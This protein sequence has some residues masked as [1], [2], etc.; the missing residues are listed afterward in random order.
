MSSS[1]RILRVQRAVGVT[2][3]AQAAFSCHLFAGSDAVM[4][5]VRHLVV[6]DRRHVYQVV[7]SSFL[8]VALQAMDESGTGVIH[9]FLVRSSSLDQAPASQR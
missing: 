3:T 1:F 8:S 6:S 4:T 7:P 5:T 9:V 2:G